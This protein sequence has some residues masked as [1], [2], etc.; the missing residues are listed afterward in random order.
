MK[1]NSSLVFIVAGLFFLLSTM[2]AL[3]LVYALTYPQNTRIDLKI[4]CTLDG[5]PCSST[6][7]CNITS[8]YPNSSYLLNNQA[9]TNLNNG[10]FNVSVIFIELGEYQTE[11]NCQDLGQNN[12]A[13]FPITIT[14]TGSI[15]STAQ[16][17]IY[18]IF[19]VVLI[20][21]FL[22]CLYG[23]IYIPWG[24]GRAEDGSIVSVNDLKYLKIVLFVASY[25]SLMFIFG[26][27]RGITANFLFMT[28]F[29]GIFN[30]MYWLLFSFLWPLLILSL[31][32]T[33]VSFL[34]NLEIKESIL[35]NIPLR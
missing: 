34:K 35:R 23:A 25:L 27:M 29:S 16:G 9:L 5:F 31:I 20:F 33:V 13:N 17:I 15:I 2:S 11:V 22:L 26:I 7:T 4:P 1:N 10:D 24:H 6:A 30:F 14:Q 28:G 8:Q 18:I 19:L 21:I 32:I 3:P 12:T